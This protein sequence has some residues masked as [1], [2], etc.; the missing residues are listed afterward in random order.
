M[1]KDIDALTAFLRAVSELNEHAKSRGKTFYTNVCA[2]VV[3]MLNS[4]ELKLIRDINKE[5]ENESES[6]T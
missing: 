4:D 1:D 3:N 6:T 5:I 2:L